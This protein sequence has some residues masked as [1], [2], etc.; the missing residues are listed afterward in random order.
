MN[1]KILDS[2]L[3]EYLHTPAS[4]QEIAKQISLTSVSIERVE[5]QN[6][7][8]IY[9]IEVTTNRPDLACVDGLAREAGAVLPQN[10]LEATYKP[11]IIPSEIKK[12]TDSDT[13][14][15]SIT[16]KSPAV[17]RVCA[18]VMEVQIG[19]SPQYISERLESSE[20]RSLNNLIDITNYVMRV[21]GQPTH[22][23]DYDRLG[24]NELIIR[25]AKLGEKITTLD[26]KTYKLNGGEIVAENKKGEI[27]DLLAIMGL[28]NS[29]VTDQT[30]RIV[31]F[32]NN[33]DS[34]K[35]RKTS[36][37][38]G[39]RTEAAQLNEKHLDPNLCEIAVQY[40][41]HLYQKLADG[42]VVSQVIDLYPHK[43]EEKHI[44]VSLQKINSIIGVDIPEYKSID[45]L[46]RL[47]F[48]VRKE[49]NNLHVTVPTIR[50]YDVTLPED[51]IEEI[52]RVYGYHNLPVKLPLLNAKQIVQ[53]EKNPFYWEQR[54][55]N[56]F[57][58][59][60]FTET[61]T[62]SMVPENLYEG[63]LDEAVTIDNPL[64]EEF[65]YMRN[66]LVPSL[67]RVVSENKSY[68]Q[69]K[70]FE[71]SN[72]YHKREN[73]LPEEIRVLAVVIKQSNISFYTIKG[74]L[75]QLFNDMGIK[76]YEFKPSDQGGDGAMIYIA[77]K[78]N[79]VIEI[80]DEN[81]L[82]FEVNFEQLIATAS[83][84]KTYNSPSK[85]PPVLEDI[86][87]VI[88]GD[89]LTQEVIDLIKKQSSL[90]TS[91]ELIDR[92]EST[93]TFHVIYQ[94]IEKNLTQEDVK[95]VH[96][97]IISVLKRKWQIHEK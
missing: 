21:T 96:E 9:D 18:V 5:K 76:N 11:L 33:I 44:T 90:V 8:F 72:V 1:I 43:S 65:V 35:V 73:S 14:D 40:G 68:D 84:R 87:L 58:Y 59:W 82:D 60:G 46:T 93:R 19:K 36:M 69:I 53:E 12:S 48:H 13:A 54:V 41:I 31:F 2:W 97:K 86:S 10:G 45:I 23:F 15:L 66:S 81:L 38:L 22:V 25:E 3:K 61:Y 42:K 26:N 77:G 34:N 70:I 67:L 39:I 62:Y 63:P 78:Q 85:F 74:Y 37:N 20:I 92:F 75:Q 27:I 32:V 4:A 16:I 91:V 88:S 24:G 89:I 57:K 64:N 94:N 28:K 71:I 50:A 52:A 51:I 29:V 56:A 80:L 49:D 47:G 6:D 55:K 17:N 30:K 7:D 95:T 79:G 83:L